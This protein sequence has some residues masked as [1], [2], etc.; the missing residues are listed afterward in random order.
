MFRMKNKFKGNQTS[1]A[2]AK[3]KKPSRFGGMVI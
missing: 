1:F 2:D 3:N